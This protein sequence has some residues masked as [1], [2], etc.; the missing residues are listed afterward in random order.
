MMASVVGPVAEIGEPARI[1]DD[2]VELVAMDDQEAP[3]V[4]GLVDGAVGDDDAA[5][6]RALELARRNSSWLPAM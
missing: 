1:V 5:E 4:G 3:A 6:M 2:G